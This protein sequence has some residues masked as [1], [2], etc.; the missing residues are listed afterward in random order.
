MRAIYKFHIA[1]GR[2]GDLEGV[3]SADTDDIKKLTD[4]GEEVYFGEVLGKHSEISKVIK[5]EHLVL[6]TTDVEFIKLFDQYDLANGF[7]P[8]DY[9]EFDGDDGMDEED[10]N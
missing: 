3:F 2:M 7:N 4:S 10:G 5:P 8:F 9:M 6:I 1:C